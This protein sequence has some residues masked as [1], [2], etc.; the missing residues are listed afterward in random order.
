MMMVGTRGEVDPAAKLP[1]IAKRPLGCAEFSAAC[2]VCSCNESDGFWCFFLF[3]GSAF[4][5]GR[6]VHGR[7]LMSA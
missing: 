6:K 7:M 5:K 1:I 3:F 4:S 2:D